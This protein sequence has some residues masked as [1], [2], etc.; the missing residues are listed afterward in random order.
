MKAIFGLFAF[1]FG[2]AGAIPVYANTENFVIIDVRTHDEFLESHVLGAL[3]IDVLSPDF[4]SKISALDKTKIYKV[5]CRSGNRSAQAMQ[6]MKSIGFKDV[7]N[8]GSLNQA[9]KRLNRQCAGNSSC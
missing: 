6:T 9:A 8:L 2:T 4:K 1:I 7:E 5:Y 3:N